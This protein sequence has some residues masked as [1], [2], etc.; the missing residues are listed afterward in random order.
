MKLSGFVPQFVRQS[1]WYR[2]LSRAR[3]VRR[4]R[5]LVASATPLNVVLGAGATEFPGWLNTDQEVL[6]IVSPDDWAQLFAPE[7]IDRLLS[8]HVLE[9]L[10]E[11]QGRLAVRE[12]YRYLKPGGLFRVAV[13]DGY[14]RDAAYVAEASPPNDGHQMLYTVDTFTTLLEGAGFVVTPLEYFDADE[15]F[16]AQPWDESEGHV[17]RSIRFDSQTDFQRD[18][19]FYTS[20]IVDA[21]K[22]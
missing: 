11:E 17:Q 19:M 16:H 14:R 13:P 7:T 2:G 20:L 10:S 12:C 21:R 5:Q 18:G 8:E 22:A 3:R 9:H 4:L 1:G 15:N 6:D